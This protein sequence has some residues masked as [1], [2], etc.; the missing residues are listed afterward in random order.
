MFG[1][2]FH[3]SFLVVGRVVATKVPSKVVLWITQRKTDRTEKVIIIRKLQVVYQFPELA[4]VG[5]TKFKYL[6]CM[7]INGF[8][9]LIVKNCACIWLRKMY[10]ILFLD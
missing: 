7:D 9:S 1:E 8:L 3:I 6:P 5:S 2:M 10:H 4:S